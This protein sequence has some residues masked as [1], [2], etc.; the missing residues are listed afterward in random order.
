MDMKDLVFSRLGPASKSLNDASDLLTH[1]IAQ[2]EGALAE[3]RLGVP[4]WIDLATMEVEAAPDWY[5]ELG[6]DKQKGRWAMLLAQGPDPEVYT[7]SFLLD[8]SREMKLQAL[9]KIPDLLAKLREEAGKLESQILTAV[10]T[11]E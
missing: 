3:L 5:V 6:Y 2:V 11:V 9:E 7:F 10:S 8:A 4:A 1:Q